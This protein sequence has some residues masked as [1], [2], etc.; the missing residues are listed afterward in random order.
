MKKP[1]K[2]LFAILLILQSFQTLFAQSPIKLRSTL[3]VSG[4]S[5]TF[6]SNGQQ[7]YLVQSI[8][9][10]SVI[11]LSQNNKYFLRQGFIQPI[12]SSIPVIQLD[13][14]R[15]EVYPNPFSANIT[16]S[17]AE[18][19]SDI[20]HVTLIDLNGRIS[21]LKL[22]PAA[23]E[24]KLNVESLAPTIYILMVRS[25]TKCFYSKMIKL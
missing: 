11:G 22:F 24:I 21:Y 18:D 13:I 1:I 3:G 17:F 16:V 19:V 15:A 6:T 5:K 20:L 4:S 23:Q 2:L 9:Q 14:L 7:Y 10:S 12:N 8:G 25:T